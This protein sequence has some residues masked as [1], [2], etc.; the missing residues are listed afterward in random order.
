M[1]NT[2]PPFF[3]AAQRSR[4]PA[5]V[6]PQPLFQDGQRRLTSAF[7]I[8]HRA[9]LRICRRRHQASVDASSFAGAAHRPA[10]RERPAFAVSVDAAWLAQTSTFVANSPEAPP[11]KAGVSEPANRAPEP[12]CSFAGPCCQRKWVRKSFWLKP[13]FCA[14]AYAGQVEPEVKHV[15]L[16]AAQRSPD[17]TSSRTR[18]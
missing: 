10:L 6:K 1:D 9:T 8:A 17:P 4:H 14:C 5:R 15:G 13:R 2:S 11:R 7:D 16:E 12:A 3:A 18:D